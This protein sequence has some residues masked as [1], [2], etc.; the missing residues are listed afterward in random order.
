MQVKGYIGI[1]GQLYDTARC[2]D[3]FSHLMEVNYTYRVINTVA[4]RP[5]HLTAQL[6]LLSRTYEALF[7]RE[8]RFDTDTV[9][10]QIRDLLYR[11]SAAQGGNL[12][13]LVA[14]PSAVTGEPDLYMF[15]GGPL[16][17][18]G[19]CV[20]HKPAAALTLTYEIPF[21]AYKTA[22]NYLCHE[23]ARRRAV[24]VG[25]HSAISVDYRGLAVSLG[26]NPLF[27]VC[28]REVYIPDAEASCPQ[29]IE[30][31][32]GIEVCTRARLTVTE[33][34]L[35]EQ[36]LMETEE[37]FSFTPQGILPVG[38]VN[39]RL[40]PTTFIRTLDRFLDRL[41]EMEFRESTD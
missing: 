8:A 10:K 38:A 12:V 39:G 25:K 28:G 3:K 33:K 40:F 29:S 23:S 22:A 16:V 35:T 14:F 34:C 7:R 26:E 11:N 24:A 9:G 13:R 32:L 4:H 1:N 21:P 41:P 20:W 36:Q 6:C 30:R 37:I 17:Y 19:Y 18:S 15:Y 27:A 5:L 2:G 31:M